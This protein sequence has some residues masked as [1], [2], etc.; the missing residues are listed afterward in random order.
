MSNVFGFVDIL[1]H[2]QSHPSTVLAIAL[3]Y[4][5]SYLSLPLPLVNYRRIFVLQNE[6]VAVHR[7]SQHND[8]KGGVV[9]IKC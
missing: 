5:V 3:L 6:G 4:L 9:D 2:I 1:F 8:R 7:C